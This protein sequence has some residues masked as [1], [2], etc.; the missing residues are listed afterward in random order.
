[1]RSVGRAQ[2]VQESFGALI[3]VARTVDRGFLRCETKRG[4]PLVELVQAKTGGNPFFTIQFLNALAEER[5][6]LRS[7]RW[8][9]ALSAIERVRAKRYTD[10]VVDLMVVKLNRLP[11]KTQAPLRQLA[12]VGA[13]AAFDSPWDRLPDSKKSFT[14]AS[15][16]RFDPGSC[17]ASKDSYAFQHDRVQEAAYSLIPREAR[18]KAHIG[19]DGGSW[20]IRRS[21]KREEIIFEMSISLTV[22]PSSSLQ[23]MSATRWLSS[24][25]SRAS[26]P[27]LPQPTPQL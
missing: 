22:E 19:S 17:L 21:D 8:A 4:E 5:C 11:A 1:M 18:A 10:N 3:H 6:C 20:R 25:W 27:K 12:C 2:T 15:G 7:R 16:K 23:K 9:M 14:R 26:E 13:S 24:T